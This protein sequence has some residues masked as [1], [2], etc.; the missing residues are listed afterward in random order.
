[1]IVDLTATT[2]IDS[3]TLGVLL[4]AARRLRLLDAELVLVCADRNILKILAI[5]L[6]DRVFTIY[7]TLSEALAVPLGTD[8]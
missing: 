7:E 6:L 3:T 1:M 8:L 5:T 2:F 4:G